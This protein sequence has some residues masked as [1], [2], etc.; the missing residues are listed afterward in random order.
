MS[1]SG[2]RRGSGLLIWTLACRVFRWR[3]AWPLMRVTVPVNV[4]SGRRSEM[5]STVWPAE[6]AAASLSGTSIRAWSLAGS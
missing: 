3:S 2:R 5:S 6:R 1:M 4:L